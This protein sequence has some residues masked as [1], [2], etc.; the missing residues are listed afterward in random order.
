MVFTPDTPCQE[1]GDLKGRVSIVKTTF[2]KIFK[3]M[4]KHWYSFQIT[5]FKITNF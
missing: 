2:R 5:P 3:I 1:I 4:K